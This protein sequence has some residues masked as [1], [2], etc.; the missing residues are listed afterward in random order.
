MSVIES[1]EE[2]K[3]R[4]PEGVRV[5]NELLVKLSAAAGTKVQ[6]LIAREGKG[7]FLRLAITGGGCS[8]LSYKMKFVESPKRGDLYVKTAGTEVVVDAKSALYLRGTEVDYSDALVAGGF[9]F[10][11]PNA[12][13]TC[14]C[15]ESFAV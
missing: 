6:K 8:G 1:V 11:N 7:T 3:A 15:G 9:K 14:S 4:L 2:V 13:G 12:K 10:T 5:G